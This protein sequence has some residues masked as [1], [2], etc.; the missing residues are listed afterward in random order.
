MSYPPPPPP[1]GAPGYGPPPGAPGYGPPPGAP[2]YGPPPGAPPPGAPGGYGPPPGAPPG[3]GGP[4]PSGGSSS[5]GSKGPLIA[6]MS[7]LVVVVLI[8]VVGGLILLSRDGD[9]TVE[10]T[11]AQLRDALLTE[12]DVGDGFT[13]DTAEE[14]DDEFDIDELDA[15]DECLDLITELDE[16]GT[17]L[18]G[19]GNADVEAQAKF[20]GPAGEQVEHTLSQGETSDLGLVRDVAETCGEI[21][22]DDGESVGTIGFEIV[23]DVV[24]VGDDSLTLELTVELTEPFEIS[25]VSLGVLWERSGTFASITTTGEVD[26]ETFATEDPDEGFLE[27]LVTRADEK[28]A[29]VIDEA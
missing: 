6:L 29:E 18:F 27:D 1:P 19:G 25:A 28:L 3:Y 2:G 16:A 21:D 5:E 15:S 17:E 4:P 10:L 22:V 12:G 23:D 20:D 13:A 24:E 14:S 7:A 11:E 26:Q 8:A 9:D